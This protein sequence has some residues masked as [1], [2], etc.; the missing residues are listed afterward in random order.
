MITSTQNRSETKVAV[1]TLASE[2]LLNME[3]STLAF[4]ERVLALAEDARI[5]LLER[6]RFLSIFGS[7]LDEFFMTRVAGFKQQVALG[8]TKPTLDGLTP[9]EQLRQIARRV[10]PLMERAYRILFAKLLPQLEMHGIRILRWAELTPDDRRYLQNYYGPNLDA[11]LTVARVNGNGHFPHVRNLRPALIVLAKDPRSGRDYKAIIELP[12]DLPRL[13]PL[14][15]GRRW[16][17]IEEIVRVSL[18]QLLPELE[19]NGAF[20]FRVARSANIHVEEEDPDEVLQAVA[21]EIA[22]RPFQAVV[23]IEIENEAP[24]D[25]RKWLLQSLR[26]EARQRGSTLDGGDVYAAPWLIDLASMS[27]VASLPLAELHYPTLRRGSP[28]PADTSLWPLLRE[29]TALVR[30]PEDSFEATVERLLAEAADDPQVRTVR[31][32]LYR[33]DRAARIVNLLRRARR[34]G[35]QVSVLVELMASFDE[36]RNIEWARSLEAANI[37]VVFAPRGLKVHAKIALIEREE[38]GELRRFFYIGTGNLNAA[39]AAAYTDLGLLGSDPL[40][41]EE[42]RR[43]F[44][45]LTGESERETFN[46]LLVAP[47]T[48]RRRFLELIGREREHARA[49]RGGAIRAKLNGLADREIIAALCAAS[50]AGVRIELVVRGMC[51][52]RPGVPGLSENIRVV[53]VLGRFLEHE[54]IYRFENAGEPEFFIG[55]ADWR[56]RNL[57]RRIEVIA[58]VRDPAHRAKL[59]G[60]LD[61]NLRDPDAW[62]LASDGSYSRVG[63]YG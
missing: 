14:P 52:L 38:E 59:D 24:D 21:A 15:G 30:F 34:H 11:A 53:S 22:K 20:V 62:E 41:G 33:T 27:T 51:A 31:V 4:N 63:V 23:R 36:R 49:G 29:R 13:I 3:M 25:V 8:S 56:P 1:G 28:L 58:P 16:V 32:T 40:L 61:A 50:Q 39:T 42:L 18:A 57:S 10:P 37:H 60:L 35:K 2:A 26:E 54:R 7:N 19:I 48:M 43:V 5:P 47:F 6:V 44:N 9:E 17:P 12:S 45:I 46:Q 55:S